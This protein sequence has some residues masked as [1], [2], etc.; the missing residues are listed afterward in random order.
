MRKPSHI[1]LFPDAYLRDN[2][3]M[4]LE[5]HGL[6]FMLMMEAWNT[7]DCSLPDSDKAL[8][9]IAG[10]S[11]AKFRKIAPQVLE[12]WTREGGRIFQKRL[13][14][15]WNYVREKSG[16]RKAAADAR[17]QQQNASK[18]NASA[19]HLGEGEGEGEGGGVP[20]Q[21]GNKGDTLDERPFRVV[22]GGGK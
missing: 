16:K 14:K 9:E 22:E 12:K 8:A 7:D 4:S 6:F 1:P 20:Y 17:W 5:Q 2:F 19:M 3:R 18:C 15:E 13:V 11:V 10:I 21:A